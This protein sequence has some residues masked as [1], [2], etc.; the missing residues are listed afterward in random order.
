MQT[1]YAKNKKLPNNPKK[2]NSRPKPRFQD[3]CFHK[4]SGK[5]PSRTEK[6]AHIPHIPYNIPHSH[7]FRRPPTQKVV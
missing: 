7:F 4:T 1:K 2:A 3:G 6:R 5:K